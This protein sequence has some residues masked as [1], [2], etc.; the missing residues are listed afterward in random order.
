MPS[1]WGFKLTVL[2]LTHQISSAR[3]PD[4]CLKNISQSS[5]NRYNQ[6]LVKYPRPSG[7]PQQRQIVQELRCVFTYVFI[8]CQIFP[9]NFSN[10]NLLAL[11]LDICKTKLHCVGSHPC[12]IW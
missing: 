6:D 11:R 10:P 9:K 2:Q 8:T 1:W 3:T 4:L 12:Q 5:T 7:K